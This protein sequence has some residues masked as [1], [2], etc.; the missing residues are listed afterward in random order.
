MALLGDSI[1]LGIGLSGTP[2]N[3]SSIYMQGIKNDQAQQAALSKA[4]SKLR[5]DEDKLLKDYEDEI[6][7]KDR[8]RYDRALLRDVRLVKAKALEDIKKYREEKPNSWKNYANERLLQ[9]REELDSF[10]DITKNWN[11]E[12][13]SIPDN[14][15]TQWVKDAIK[16]IEGAS[17]FADVQNL[18][19]DP[20]GSGS[21]E[22][23]KFSPGY[24]LSPK[25]SSLDN[26]IGSVVG[27]AK[28]EYISTMNTSRLGTKEV[29]EIIEVG[30]PY[31]RKAAQ[32]L[33]VKHKLPYTPSSIED[34]AEGMMEDRG[35]YNEVL[36]RNRQ[37]LIDDPTLDRDQLVKEELMKVAAKYNKVT[38]TSR[39]A[40]PTQPKTS[41]SSSDDYTPKELTPEEVKK[42][43]VV[44]KSEA[45]GERN[46]SPEAAYVIPQTAI[47][48]KAHRYSMDVNNVEKRK[49]SK[50]DIRVKDLV[51]MH[52]RGKISDADFKNILLEMRVDPKD[53]NSLGEKLVLKNGD[54]VFDDLKEYDNLFSYNEKWVTVGT[55]EVID[56]YGDTEKRQRVRPI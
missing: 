46:A 36:E 23:G 27:K 12:L 44:V 18:G 47:K 11:D 32:D 29:S 43:Y 13:R 53:V 26:A 52:Q 50:Q 22:K 9:A 8:N 31:D 30:M 7:I 51:G 4:Q 49:F 56:K 42:R 40:S 37:K 24:R 14:E 38:S 48:S 16:N 54:V 17:S 5:D 15:K 6:V 55:G 25:Y 39:T 10:A 34:I 45:F 2:E 1:G 3:Y 41:S 20:L 33:Q 35:A 28:N 21:F 19:S